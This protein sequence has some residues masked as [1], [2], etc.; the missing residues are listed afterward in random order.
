M[1]RSNFISLNELSGFDF[2]NQLDFSLGTCTQPPAAYLSNM[3]SYHRRVGVKL[4]G[5]QKAV[6]GSLNKG[7]AHGLPCVLCASIS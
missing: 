7:T 4:V 5:T 1:R 3:V 2:E 6:V